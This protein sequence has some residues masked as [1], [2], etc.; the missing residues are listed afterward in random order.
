[1][2]ANRPRVFFHINRC[3]LGISSRPP[4]AAAEASCNP[5]APDGG[6]ARFRTPPPRRCRRHDVRRSIFRHR[7]PLAPAG[8]D[9][10]L[11]PR[12]D[13][14][15]GEYGRPWEEN[16]DGVRAPAGEVQAIVQRAAVSTPG[17]AP[18]ALRHPH[19]CSLPA[20]TCPSTA[21]SSGRRTLAA[22]STS[23]PSCG[24]SSSSTARSSTPSTGWNAGRSGRSPP[25]SGSCTTTISEY[26]L[27]KC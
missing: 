4:T 17:L 16:R 22:P 14:R 15:Y 23:T 27:M 24:S 8:H 9:E 6:D 13:G 7:Q 1:M 20:G 26:T 21:T 18:S 25:R 2:F 3:L 19:V 10:A 12:K 5:D 11:R